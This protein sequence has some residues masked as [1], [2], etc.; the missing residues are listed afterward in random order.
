MA[1]TKLPGDDLLAENH[2]LKLVLGSLIDLLTHKRADRDQ[3][4]RELFDFAYRSVDATGWRNV[5]ADRAEMLREMTR[6]RITAF[7][8]T[9]Q[10]PQDDPKAGP[11]R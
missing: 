9:L 10:N 1:W 3:Q 8:S 11:P 6:E 2:A 7:F 4:L 5:D